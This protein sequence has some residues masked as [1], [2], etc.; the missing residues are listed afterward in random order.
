[1]VLSAEK[2][3]EVSKLQF[4]NMPVVVQQQVPMVETVEKPVVIPQ[5][6]FL[7]KVVDMPVVF[8]DK[9]P[10]SRPCGSPWRFHRCP[11]S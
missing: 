4:I 8:N 5:V 9:C 1:M 11:W 6:R 3:V 10:W 2:T 7:W